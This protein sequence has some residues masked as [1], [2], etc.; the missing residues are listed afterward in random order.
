MLFGSIYVHA[1]LL[2]DWCFT[3]FFMFLCSSKVHAIFHFWCSFFRILVFRQIGELLICG[4]CFL[5]RHT[6]LAL[7]HLLL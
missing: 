4:T 6:N 7:D 1:R 2:P 3:S 5:A